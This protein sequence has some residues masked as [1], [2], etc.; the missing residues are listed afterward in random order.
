[1]S[2]IP[3]N[4]KGH[5]SSDDMKVA[6]GGFS[7]FFAPTVKRQLWTFMNYLDTGSSTNA[8]SMGNGAPEFAEVNSS[9]IGS[10][11]CASNDD[12]YSTLW[13][14]P[15]ELDMT[16]EIKFRVFWSES[17]TLGT[18]SALWVIAH[19]ELVTD[20]TTV[21]VGSNVLDTL[22]T[23]DTPSTTAHCL[24]AC[25]QGAIAA[26]TLTALGQGVNTVAIMTSC[27]LDTISDA[28]AYALEIEYDR[29][30]VGLT[31]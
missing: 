24:Q 18:G 16:K 29:R 27:T 6:G 4:Y 26:N 9:E 7:Q 22:I 8:E 28:S 12:A 5:E 23:V 13:L 3:I 19:L 30:F 21:A 10:V 20:T 1:M 14:I 25:P 11:L 15:P 17:G 31:Y 2:M